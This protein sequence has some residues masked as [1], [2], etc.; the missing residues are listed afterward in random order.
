[1]KKNSDANIT[2]AAIRQLREDA[3]STGWGEV[4]FDVF[5]RE[6]V[7]AAVVAN[8]PRFASC[9]KASGSPKSQA[10]RYCSKSAD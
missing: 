5:D 7:L 8:G 2:H 10:A 6:P 3:K 1:M 4:A 9:S